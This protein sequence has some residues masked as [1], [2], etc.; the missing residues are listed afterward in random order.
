MSQDLFDDYTFVG[1]IHAL[2]AVDDAVR[3][4]ERGGHGVRVV[5]HNYPGVYD[6][7][8]LYASTTRYLV[9]RWGNILLDG[10]GQPIEVVVA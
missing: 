5:V 1:S 10:F 8:D 3:A 2:L 9:D 6:D 4:L 7:Y